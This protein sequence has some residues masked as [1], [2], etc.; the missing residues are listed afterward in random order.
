MLE[1][2]TVL[3]LE[4]G[5]DPARV[6]ALRRLPVGVELRAAGGVDVRVWAPRC[7]SVAFV[8]E[9]SSGHPTE[10]PLAAEADG[11]FAGF[12]AEASP[13]SRYRFRLDGGS[14]YPD[15]AS[16][17]QPDGPHGPS[18]VV[19]PS[20]F[21]WSDDDWAGVALRGAVIYELHIGTFTQASN[22]AAA[23]AELPA[24]RDLGVTVIEVM[25]IADF[26]GRFGWGYDGV[27]LFAP[28]RLYGTPDDAR[29]FVDDAH[30]LGMGVILDLVYNHLGPDGNYLAAFSDDYRSK[31]EHTEW[32]DGFNFDRENS[33]PVRE[34]FVSNARYWIEE[35]HFDGCRLD[36]TQQIFDD[37]DR[38]IIAEVTAA[39]RDAAGTRRVIVIA[40]NERQNVQLVA[41]PADGGCGLDGLWNDDFHHSATV[42]L[43]GRNE[44]YYSQHHGTAQELISAAKY[45]FLYQGQYYAWQQQARGTPALGLPSEIAISYL[46]NHDQVAN[47]ARSSRIHQLTDASQLRALTALLLLGPSTPM[48]FQGQE[49]AASSPFSYFADHQDELAGLV[50]A[51]RADSF[52]QFPSVM[53]FQTTSDMAVPTAMTT[54][55]ASKLDHAERERNAEVYTLH[56]DLLRLR[57]DDPVFRLQAALGIDGAVIGDEA[58]VLRFFGAEGDD[59]LLI[60]NLGRDVVLLPMPEPLL[61]P[62]RRGPWR[63]FW[64]SEEPRYGGSGTPPFTPNASWR[65]AAHSA[66]VLLPS[67]G[68]ESA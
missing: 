52:R 58:L 56:R 15:P 12:V 54:F 28:S 33:A 4:R 7:H 23:R 62:S 1:G 41:S 27:N 5:T 42:A 8:L 47:S 59:R 46:Q 31:G 18:V 63:L 21:V 48:L 32:G 13:G 39:I 24:L 68:Q 65:L 45:G 36:A 11:Y 53:D 64:S 49:F 44:A 34:L 20:T 61:A 51:G 40:E 17:F 66:I 60:L 37:S 10:T 16:R 14:A 6:A 30:R 29:Q 19:D 22:W 2:A 38:H 57:R 9:S 55:M 43:T 67:R 50:N 3:E 26:P 25:P 35:F